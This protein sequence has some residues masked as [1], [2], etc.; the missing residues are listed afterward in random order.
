MTWRERRREDG[1]PGSLGRLVLPQRLDHVA[2]QRLR[3]RP[4]IARLAV[5]A[6]QA[7]A[8]AACGG[9]D[10]VV[11]LGVEAADDAGQHG[12]APF[13]CGGHLSRW[14]APHGALSLSSAGEY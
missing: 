9:G 4:L 2:A 14:G 1:P 7:E 6:A 13:G 3:H 10:G 12:V 8:A 5:V 11:E